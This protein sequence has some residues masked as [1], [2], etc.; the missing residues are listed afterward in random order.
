MQIINTEYQAINFQ[1]GH[2]DFEINQDFLDSL[3]NALCEVNFITPMVKI[4]TEL[5][6][7]IIAKFRETFNHF[8]DVSSN[9]RCHQH[10]NYKYDGVFTTDEIRIGLEIQFRPDFLKD[11]TRFQLGFHSNRI[12]AMIYIVAIDRNTINPNYNS[13]P[14]Y[15]LV[16]NHLNQFNWLQIPILVVGINCDNNL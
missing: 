5:S 8:S 2:N 4:Q 11:I 7:K 12:N 10:L 1:I 15:H 14:Q 16:I 9:I 6:N 3:H 13:M